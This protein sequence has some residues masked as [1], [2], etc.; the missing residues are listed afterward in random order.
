MIQCQSAEFNAITDSHE[1]YK[2]ISHLILVGLDSSNISTP[3][4]VGIHR[5]N[6]SVAENENLRDPIIFFENKMKSIPLY[7]LGFFL[8][9]LIME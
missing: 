9:S 3:A 2:L 4:I 7:L 6:F 1:P 5:K 8:P